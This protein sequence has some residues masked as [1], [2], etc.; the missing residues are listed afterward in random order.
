MKSDKQIKLGA[1]LSYA[2]MALNVIV[3]M[4]YTPLMIRLLGQSEYGLYNTVA[5]TISMLSI[6]NLGFGSGYI[7]YFAKYKSNKDTDSI[8]KLN[9]LFLMVFLIIGS[10]ALMCGLYL[11]YN[12][13]LVFDK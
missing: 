11:T 12:L 1:V 2:Q 4:I 9:G 3:G 6:L 13:E 7:R 5:S 10:I 8:N